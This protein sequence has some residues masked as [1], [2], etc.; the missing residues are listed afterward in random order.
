MSI[1]IVL[2]S[3]LLAVCL[4]AGAPV[5]ADA[6][7]I[8]APGEG[9]AP[10]L[11]STCTA[12]CGEYTD[13]SCAA[14]EC[15]ARNRDCSIQQRGYVVCDGVYSYCPRCPPPPACE[16]GE[17]K[18]EPTGYCCGSKAYW[19]DRYRCVDGSWVLYGTYCVQ[20]SFYCA[21]PDPP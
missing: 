5:A 16:P 6:G 9:S 13:V 8:G 21:N 20:T 17:I 12:D 15:T 1:L 18:R 19:E 11:E 7:A 14:I 4:G 2:Q 10:E 3:S